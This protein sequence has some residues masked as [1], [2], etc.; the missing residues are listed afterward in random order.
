MMTLEKHARISPVLAFVLIGSISCQIACAKKMVNYG[1]MEID[2]NTLKVRL[3]DELPFSGSQRSD[4]YFRFQLPNGRYTVDHFAPGGK[5]RYDAFFVLADNS[6]STRSKYQILLSGPY[7]TVYAESTYFY[8]PSYHKQPTT[9]ESA[10]YFNNLNSEPSQLVSAL[11]AAENLR[12]SA[13][14]VIRVFQAPPEF[15]VI[16]ADY[17]PDGHLGRVHVNGSKHGDWVH[18]NEIRDLYPGLDVATG[19]GDW[20][21]TRERFGIPKSFPVKEYQH[22]PSDVLSRVELKSALDVVNFHYDRNLWVQQDSSL[23]DGTNH[24]RFLTYVATREDRILQSID[25]AR[26]FGQIQA[27][28]RASSN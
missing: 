7:G 11:P 10:L 26:P 27:I 20:P 25:S 22:K 19:I 5:V 28:P 15:L 12:L 1:T 13:I 17:A 6:I 16:S 18:S 3:G 2:P 14:S 8:D 21:K 9:F 4:Y 23:P 24:T